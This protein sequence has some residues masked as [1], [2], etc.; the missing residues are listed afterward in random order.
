MVEFQAEEFS[1]WR[2]RESTKYL[3]LAVH[4]HTGTFFKGEHQ[5]INTKFL[6]PNK[7]SHGQEN[8]YASVV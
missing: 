6:S 4:A 2:I 8:R 5:H 7:I 3:T 1:S